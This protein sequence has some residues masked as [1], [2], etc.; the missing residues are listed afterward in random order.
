MNFSLV[1][2]KHRFRFSLFYVLFGIVSIIL[3][4]LIRKYILGELPFLISSFL[5]VVIGVFVS[6]YLNVKFNFKIAKPKRNRALLYFCLISFFSY[7]LQIFLIQLELLDLGYEISRFTTAGI[8]FWVGY[9]F[10]LK[11][12][13]SDYKKVGVAIYA[14]GFENIPLIYNKIGQ[15]P[16]FIHVDIVDKT[17][18]EKAKDV[19]TY[20]TEVIKAY[21]NNKSIEVHIMSK[22]PKKWILNVADNVDKIFIHT[23]IDDNLEDILDL[24][25]SKS[26]EAGIVIHKLADLDFF[27]LYKKKIKHLLVL[28]IENPGY[29]GQKFDN[30]SLKIIDKINNLKERPNITLCVDGGVNNKTIEKIYSENVVSGSYVINSDSSEKNIVILQTSSKY[31]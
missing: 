14:N 15:Y 4:L 3:E 13:F 16:D 6:F 30:N 5:S 17:F 28:S 7:S 18:N 2:I 9:L 11:F 21:W 26:C 27:E 24:I 23:N 31:E 1:F 29:S 12:S 20:K 10:H 19:L 8:F 25:N 22:K